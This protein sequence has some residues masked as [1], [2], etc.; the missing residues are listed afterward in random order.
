MEYIAAHLNHL[1]PP[2]AAPPGSPALPMD[3]VRLIGQM[4][5]KKREDRPQTYRDITDRLVSL[6]RSANAPGGLHPREP[7]PG[8]TEGASGEPGAM[9]PGPTAPTQLVA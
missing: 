9:P 4:L 8:D 7:E 6:L 5:E 2:V 3:L 1:P